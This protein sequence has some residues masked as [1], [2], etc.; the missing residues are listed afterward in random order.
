[1][2]K[3]GIDAFTGLWWSGV[4]YP[5]EVGPLYSPVVR[6]RTGAFAVREDLAFCTHVIQSVDEPYLAVAIAIRR[7]RELYGY[8][9]AIGIGIEL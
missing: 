8:V 9:R 6:Y 5:K 2:G 7:I 1:M 4:I 3:N